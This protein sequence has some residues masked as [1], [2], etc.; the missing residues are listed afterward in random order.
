MNRRRR[1]MNMVPVD[2]W[3]PFSIL[4][5]MERAF[6]SFRMGFDD[7]MY[8]SARMPI[9]DIRDEKKQYVVEAELPGVTREDVEIEVGDDVIYLEAQTEKG[10]EEK[11]EGYIRRERGHMSFYRRVPIPE[12]V[13]Q[14]KIG[15]KLENGVLTVILPKREQ[16]A[17]KKRKIGI[18]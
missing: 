16:A 11:G 9:M 14:E 2:Y 15:A 13:D 12:D 4:R 1:D 10:V 18:K 6:D 3:N 8:P 5:E 17:K 7:A